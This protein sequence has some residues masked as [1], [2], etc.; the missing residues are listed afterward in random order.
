MGDVITNI[1]TGF[2]NLMDLNLLFLLLGGGI[3]GVIIGAL[4]GFT[5]TMGV[6]L[7]VPFTFVM[8]PIYGLA[9]LGVVYATAVYGGSISAILLNI[10]GAPANIATIFDGYPMACK[11]EGERA[12]YLSLIASFCGGIIGAFCLMFCAPPLTALALKFGPAENFWVAIFGLTIIASLGTT[13]ELIKGLIGGCIGILLS[14][15]GISP[16]T[17]QPRFTFGLSELTGGISLVPALIGLFAFTQVFVSF[18]KYFKEKDKEIRVEIIR[19]KGAFWRAWR[20]VLKSRG[21]PFYAGL[22]GSIIGI[23]PGAGGQVAGIVA[24]DQAKRLSKKRELFGKGIAEGVIAPE[25][26]NNG[27]VGGALVP[28]LTL[29]IPGSPTA[30]VLLGGILIHGLWPGPDL[31][32]KHPEIPYTFMA[33]VMVGQVALLICGYFLCRYAVMVLRTPPFIL[34]PAIIVLCV[35]GSYAVQNNIID[36]CFMLILGVLGYLGIKIGIQP[37]PVVLGLILGPI[38]ENGLLLGVRIGEAKGLAV[39]YFITRPL[40]II[41]IFIVIVSIISTVLLEVRSRRM[42]GKAGLAAAVEARPKGL[43]TLDARLGFGIMCISLLGWASYTASLPRDTGLWPSIVLLFLALLGAIQFYRGWCQESD[44]APAIPWK[45]VLEIGITTLILIIAGN[46]LGFYTAAFLFMLYMPGRILW[47][48]GMQ[49]NGKQIG[50]ILVVS[51]AMIVI[52]YLA[53]GLFLMVPTPRGLL[54]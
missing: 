6:A 16:V 29:G 18:E 23:V 15:I 33:S 28:L 20:E 35:F 27:S 12:L 17:G 9:L 21:L 43:R 38:A 45:F 36:V 30:A 42:A 8:P 26:A 24:Y 40:S 49:M 37:A 31:F 41:L 50:A 5:P 48:R 46:I 51:I 39:S 25:A 53:F 13:R 54:V 47:L 7:L 44:P 11:G 34:A 32:I 52:L 4:P 1:L 10:P 2:A 14:V 22:L 19:R 3:L